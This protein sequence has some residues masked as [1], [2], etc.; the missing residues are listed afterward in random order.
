[1]AATQRSYAGKADQIQ[2]S[3]LARQF[4][5]ENLH[6]SD[7]P[8]RF[9]SWALDQPENVSLWFD[10]SQQLV[11]WAILNTPFWIIDYAYHPMA[12]PDL[13]QEILAWADQRARTVKETEY[14]HPAWFALAFSGQT[15][16]IRNLEKAG[17]AC[18][19]DV[20][21]DSWSKVLMQRSAQT[22]VKR[23]KPPAGFTV[24]PLAGE[25]EVQAYVELHRATFESKNM[26]IDWRLRTLEHPDYT[27]DLDL[28]VEA[29]DGR[30]GAFCIGW[31][32][33]DPEGT[34]VGQVEPLGCHPDFRRYALGRVALAEGLTR[35]QALGA[36]EIFVET[37]SYRNTAF[38]LYESFGFEV[39]QD[40]LVYRKD[41]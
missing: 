24:R 16:R 7:L 6:V 36:Q 28:V 26:T 8:Y 29:P 1:M 5:A 15:G 22:P 13:H 31:L 19:A 35:L 21:E 27:A 32:G 20:G 41:Y 3:A 40:V 23:Y 39:I 10:E 11:A 4:F 38:R 33:K 2:M 34:L 18:Q 12:E 17:F 25:K 14:G 30:L 37:D 9:S